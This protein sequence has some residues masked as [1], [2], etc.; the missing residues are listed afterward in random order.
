MSRPTRRLL[1]TE[2]EFES[3]IEYLTPWQSSVSREC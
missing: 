1:D 2:D 3:E